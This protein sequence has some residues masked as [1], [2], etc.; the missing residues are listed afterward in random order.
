MIN[1][2]LLFYTCIHNIYIYIIIIIIIIN[3]IIIIIIVIIIIIITKIKTNFFTT[4]IFTFFLHDISFEDREEKHEAKRS[5]KISFIFPIYNNIY[6]LIHK[7]LSTL[8][9][10]SKHSYICIHIYS[11]THSY[12]YVHIYIY[13]HTIHTYMC[14][15]M[16]M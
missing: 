9:I 16:Y 15:Y 8:V 4:L 13:I 12:T 7:L 3:I 11:Y 2:R 5:V 1:P 14:T 10:L 6:A